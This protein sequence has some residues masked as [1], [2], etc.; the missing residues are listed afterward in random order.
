MKKI[1]A[2]T[3]LEILTITIVVGIGLLS[4][5]FAINKSKIDTNNII[6]KNVANR[7]AKEGVE[8]MY[9]NRNTNLLRNLDN[10]D[11]CWLNIDS[12]N[13]NC[14]GNQPRFGSGNYVLSGKSFIETNKVLALSGGI[15]EDDKFFAL[16]LK[17]GSRVACPGEENQTKYGRY[18][19]VIKGFGLYDKDS[20]VTGGNLLEC[21]SGNDEDCSNN[22][23]KEYR[24]CSQVFFV[25]NKIGKT[26]VCAIMTNFYD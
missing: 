15:S 14:N 6:Q 18:F 9:Q 26:E 7:L 19:R 3:M 10:R 17:S 24:F 12:S 22:L 23:P 4:I 8:L 20:T 21:A 16:C 2:F 1:K 25:G 13:E 11:L 5:V